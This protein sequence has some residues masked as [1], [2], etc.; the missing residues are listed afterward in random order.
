MVRLRRLILVPAVGLALAAGCDSG[1]SGMGVTNG[2]APDVSAEKPA[3][4]TDLPTPDTLG[5]GETAGAVAGRN[6]DAGTGGRGGG[7]TDPAQPPGGLPTSPRELEGTVPATPPAIE[8]RAP[9][10]PKGV[11]RP[12]RPVRRATSQSLIT[13]R[14]VRVAARPSPGARAS[15]RPAPGTADRG[16]RCPR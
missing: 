4:R 10:T 5:P 12:P 13:G 15:G 6:T 1:P 2:P 16:R 8:P 14:P 11:P 3:M 9:A 7:A